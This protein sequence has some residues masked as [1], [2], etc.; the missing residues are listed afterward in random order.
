[1]EAAFDGRVL[2]SQP[3]RLPA[4]PNAAQAGHHKQVGDSGALRFRE[5]EASTGDL[6]QMVDALKRYLEKRLERAARTFLSAHIHQTGTSESC[7][8]THHD[9]PPSPPLE[10]G[11]RNLSDHFCL[12]SGRR[13]SPPGPLSCE[14]RGS[15]TKCCVNTRRA[16]RNVYPTF[17]HASATARGS[18]KA[19][20]RRWK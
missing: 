11:R 20:V 6:S 16:D 17:K 4:A 9:S 15:R 5:V 10:K 7:V 19:I 2:T 12:H 18:R 14:E 13:T 3:V 8:R 1:M